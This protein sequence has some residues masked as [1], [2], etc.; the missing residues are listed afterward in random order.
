MK[1]WRLNHHWYTL[2]RCSCCKRAVMRTQLNWT[3]WRIHVVVYWGLWISTSTMATAHL[4]TLNA[5]N[6]AEEPITSYLEHVQLFFTAN[7][8][9]EGKEGAH[10]S[11]HCWSCNLRNST[12]SLCPCTSK[13]CAAN[14]HFRTSQEAREPLLLSATTFTKGINS[15]ERPSLST[16]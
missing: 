13:F 9:D 16:T 1:S 14:G 6:S 8:V 10:I 2:R 7:S 15:K 12:R 11:Q 4:G 5:F 3:K